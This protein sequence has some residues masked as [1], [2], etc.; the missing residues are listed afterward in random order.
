MKTGIKI[1]DITD[2]LETLAPPPYQESYDNSGL[3][4]G[5]P[6]AEVQG[7]LVTLDCLEAVV[8]RSHTIKV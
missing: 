2:Y 6:D 4:V 1:K 5:D 3:L 8:R 7:I